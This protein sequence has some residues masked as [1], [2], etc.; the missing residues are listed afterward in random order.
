MTKPEC[1]KRDLQQSFRHL[2]LGIYSCLGISCFVI[3]EP[4]HC[5]IAHGHLDNRIL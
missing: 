1:R 5:R 2:D 4:Q 3:G